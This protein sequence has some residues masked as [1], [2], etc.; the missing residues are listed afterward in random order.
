MSVR[1]Y[2]VISEWSYTSRPASLVHNIDTLSARRS[3]TSRSLTIVTVTNNRPPNVL[4]WVYGSS[5]EII[6]R[7]SI[8]IRMHLLFVCPFGYISIF[9]NRTSA[10]CRH[11]C[12]WAARSKCQTNRRAARFCN[13][14]TVIHES[15]AVV[16]TKEL[17]SLL[18]SYEPTDFRFNVHCRTKRFWFSRV[19][20]SQRISDVFIK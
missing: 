9:L 12:F 5:A 20:T 14:Y 16:M 8:S 6:V 18:L 13:F 2:G 7:I 15:Y 11:G 3:P 19:V 1:P 17:L 4:I 10:R